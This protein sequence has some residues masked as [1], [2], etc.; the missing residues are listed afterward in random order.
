MKDSIQD[1]WIGNIAPS[2]SCGV[3]DPEIERLIVM[4]ERNKDTLISTLC[5]TQKEIWDK[6]SSCA[7]EY[8]YLISMQSFVDGF[9]LASKLLTEALTE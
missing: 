5:T 1:L 8:T 4:I 3:G 6:Y 7:E 9:C 2:E